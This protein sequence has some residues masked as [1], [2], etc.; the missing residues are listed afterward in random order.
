LKALNEND[1]LLQKNEFQYEYEVKYQLQEGEVW[2][3]PGG[4]LEL[5]SQQSIEL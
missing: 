4:I 5:I 2:H 3:G 1:K